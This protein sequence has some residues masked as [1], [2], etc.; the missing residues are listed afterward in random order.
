VLI[1]LIVVP[2]VVAYLAIVVLGHVLLVAA[3]CKCLREDYMGG[4]G[5]K[6]ASWHPRVIDGAKAQAEPSATKLATHA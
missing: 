5:R 2:I 3:I 4:R 6:T 1:E